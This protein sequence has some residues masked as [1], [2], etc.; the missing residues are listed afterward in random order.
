VGDHRD[1]LAE[2]LLQAQELLVQPLADDRVDGAERL[3]HQHDRRVGGERAGHADALLLA[4]GELGGVAAGELGAEADP[5]EQLQ[6]VG[7]GLAAGP[8]EQQRNGGDVVEH[9]AVREEPGMLDDVADAAAQQRLVPAGDVLAVDEHPPRR[10]ADHPVDHAERR[11]LATAGR[12][13]QYRGLAG[14][15]LEREVVHGSAAAGVDL[16]DIV[17]CDHGAP[18]L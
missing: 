13:H 11:G 8:A 2:V 17:K 10:R 18:R 3:V 16:H 7:A 14:R 9:G 1:R 5:F 15:E 6:R 4:A 12:S